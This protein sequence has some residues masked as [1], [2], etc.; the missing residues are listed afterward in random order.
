MFKSLRLVVLSAALCL[1]TTQAHAFY[2]ALIDADPGTDGI[3]GSREVQRGTTFSVDLV[4]VDSFSTPFDALT[5]AIEFN[6]VPFAPVLA[7]G[8]TGPTWSDVPLFAPGATLDLN[9]SAPVP[10]IPGTPAAVGAAVPPS[11]PTGDVAGTFGLSSVDG[12]FAID[13]PAL[14]VSVLTID[15]TAT[16]IGTTDIDPRIAGIFS[17]DVVFDLFFFLGGAPVFAGVTNVGASITVVPEPLGVLSFATGLAGL[18][19]FRRR[20]RG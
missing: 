1:L 5:F 20:R 12:P 2:L 11:T 19:L 17:P 6:T 7:P 16:D 15:F 8:P 10:L 14:P 13:P 3:Q 18:G 4:V 9:A